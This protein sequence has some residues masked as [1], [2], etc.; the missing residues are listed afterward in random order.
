MAAPETEWPPR[1]YGWRAELVN[2][3]VVDELGEAP[4]MEEWDE[5]DRGAVSLLHIVDHAQDGEGEVVTLDAQESVFTCRG[6]DLR[7]GVN[8]EPFED[9]PVHE[10]VQW[11]RG[12][13]EYKNGVGQSSG[14]LSIEIGYRRSFP[15]LNVEPK[16]VLHARS[17]H[18]GMEVRIAGAGVEEGDVDVFLDGDLVRTE[19]QFRE[20]VAPPSLETAG[21]APLEGA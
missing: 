16:V 21:E 11:K 3:R 18:L 15:A 2:G 13:S 10:L 1:R 14:L 6:H 7:F 20:R 19:R 12:Y 5:L 4:P 8:G 9:G 17:G